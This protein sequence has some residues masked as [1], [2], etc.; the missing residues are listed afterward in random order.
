MV[1]HIVMWR[2]KG[3]NAASRREAAEFVKSRFESLKGQI[4]G[5][6]QLEIGLNLSDVDYACDLVLY[7]EFDSQEALDAY[8]HHPAHLRVRQELGDTRCA[9]YQVDYVPGP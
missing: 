2:V 6:R 5:L 7:T 4:P 3:E 8:A 1:K 9:R